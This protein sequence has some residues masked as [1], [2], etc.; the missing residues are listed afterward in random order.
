MLAG[1]RTYTRIV[2]K[3]RE[4]GSADTLWRSEEPALRA[5]S[6]GVLLLPGEIS[7]VNANHRV[8]VYKGKQPANGTEASARVADLLALVPSAREETSGGH[9][10]V[11]IH[12]AL[13]EATASKPG[14]L[15]LFLAIALEAFWSQGA[16]CFGLMESAQGVEW[17]K[18]VRDDEQ[19]PEPA[20]RHGK[21]LFAV[22]Q[23]QNRKEFRERRQREQNARLMNS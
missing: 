6:T 22:M 15:P 21:N 14:V 12:P 20:V 5:A 11:A 10:E 16:N 1:V 8:L 23:K 3:A 19:G 2:S 17:T 7:V 9:Y 18:K 13:E 4:D